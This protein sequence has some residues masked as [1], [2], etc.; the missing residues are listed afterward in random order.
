MKE[1]KEEQNFKSA[2][3]LILAGAGAIASA[4]PGLSAVGGMISF[5]QFAWLQENQVKFQKMVE[6]EFRII[7]EKLDEKIDRDA[8]ESDEFKSLMLEIVEVAMKSSSELKRQA[9]AKAIVNSVTIPKSKFTGKSILLRIISQMSDEEMAILQLLYEIKHDKSKYE[10]KYEGATTSHISYKLEWNKEDTL[11]TCQALHQL[12]LVKEPYR[13][14]DTQ[15]SG[16]P[17]DIPHG[18]G[19]MGN[20]GGKVYYYWR[21]TALAE[22]LIKWCSDI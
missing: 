14:F 15:P 4:I 6:N 20:S 17:D 7:G 13:E 2:A 10:S 21:I 16:T 1:D 5:G 19:S 11:V 9:L 18:T 8:I 22:K 12:S 3:D